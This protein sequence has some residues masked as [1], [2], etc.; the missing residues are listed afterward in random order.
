MKHTWKGIKF[1]ISLKSVASSL[2]TEGWTIT[3]KLLYVAAYVCQ[4][5]GVPDV[6]GKIPK[7]NYQA[8]LLPI[9]FPNN[10]L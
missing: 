6:R 8:Y 4:K 5:F 1:F 3:I 10:S 9:D 7:R 2:L